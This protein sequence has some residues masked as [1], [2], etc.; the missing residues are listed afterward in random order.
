V[1]GSR[2][3]YGTEWRPSPKAGFGL[4]RDLNQKTGD[5][6][7]W[8]NKMM[9]RTVRYS[10]IAAIIPAWLLSVAILIS[11]AQAQDNPRKTRTALACGQ[12]LKNNAAVC[13]CWQTTCSS[14]CKR[15]KKNFPQDALHG[16][17]MLCAA[18]IEMQ[19][20][21]AKTSSRVKAIFSDA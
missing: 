21:F 19:R 3:P 5:H 9:Q 16:P 8:E 17:T 18:V 14:A 1:L 15:T 4:G 10:A 11:A 6:C 12:E 2:S 20:N 7:F 13:Q